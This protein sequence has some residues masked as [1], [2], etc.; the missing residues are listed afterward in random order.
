MLMPNEID[1]LEQLTESLREIHQPEIDAK[2]HG[3]KASE[4]L[5]C[6]AIKR[7]ER[8]LKGKN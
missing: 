1:V 5:Y 6:R 4:C 2:H 3:D 8:V 7:A